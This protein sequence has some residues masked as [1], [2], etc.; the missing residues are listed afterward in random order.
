MWDDLCLGAANG[1][2]AC[3]LSS[4]REMQRAAEETE[5]AP[6]VSP[7]QLEADSWTNA[8]IPGLG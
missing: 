8:T 5:P 4:G 2:S 3:H 1:H 7:A 6:A